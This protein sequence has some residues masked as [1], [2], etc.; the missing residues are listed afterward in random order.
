M[1]RHIALALALVVVPFAPPRFAAQVPDTVRV[2]SPLLAHAHPTLTS[3]TVDNYVVTAG[4]RSLA[5]T[6]VRTITR[7]D[8]P[9]EPVFEIRTA[10][11]TVGGDTSHT[12][13]VVR[14]GDLS[15]VFHRVKAPRDSAAVTASR[16]HLTGWVVLPD[17]PVALLDRTLAHPV[18]GVEGQVPWLFPL[19][20]L[21]A[22]YTAVVQ[23]FSP[24]DGGERWDSITVVGA[25]RVTIGRRV[26]D[27][28]KVD[29]GAVGPPGYRMVR[30]VDRDSRRVVQSALRGP[31]AEREYWSYLR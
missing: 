16:G 3:D 24:W 12:T 1:S 15:L 4:T 26:F 21:A 23:H 29:V 20:P 13:M 2:G 10:H 30:W 7:R 8:D 18:F 9:L 6:T 17:R 27:C 11:W 22:G 25:E 28:W 5:G 14:A 31:D 19:L